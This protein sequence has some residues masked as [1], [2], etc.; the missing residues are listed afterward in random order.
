MIRCTKCGSTNWH[1][2]VR[3]PVDPAN[4]VFR[5]ADC[6]HTFKRYDKPEERKESPADKK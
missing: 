5:C 1:Y 3:C 4:D 6:K 2:K